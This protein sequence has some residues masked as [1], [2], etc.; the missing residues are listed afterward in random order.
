MSRKAYLILENGIV[1]E[2]ES[3]GAEKE[4]MGELVFTTAMTGYLETLTDPSYYGQV[5]LQTF[6]LIGNYGVI[7]ADFET[8]TPVLKGYIVREWCQAPSN[9]RC[10]GQLD[11][12][13][14]EKGVPGICGIDTRALTRIVREYGVL[15]CKI[16]YKPD[17]TDEEMAALKAYTIKDAVEST[18]CSEQEV[19][20]PEGEE[21]YNV[22]LMDFGAKHNIG[23]ELNKRGCKLTVVPAHTSAEEILAL[24]PDGIMLSN[25]P[26]DPAENVQVIEE[27]KKLCTANIPIFG[28]CLGHQ[29]LALAQGGKTAKL[30]YG[31]RGANQPVKELSSGRVFITSQ[32]HGYA[33]VSDSLHEGAEVSFVNGN[34]GTCEGVVYSN[35]PAFSV[36]FHPEA[37]GGPQE[38]S[39]LFDK[40]MD[41]IKENK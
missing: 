1:F 15:N 9:F 33:V 41:M 17:M 40:F 39:F 22:V 21:K 18:T 6:P 4:T 32:N 13:L 12:F 19:F 35:M 31:H 24:D 11:A 26:G 14:K 2:G 7:P 20:M 34:D 23:R 36:Q 27:L 37:C 10:E 28:I 29:L 5:V 25:G 38:T 30:H 3:F 16:Q 8:D